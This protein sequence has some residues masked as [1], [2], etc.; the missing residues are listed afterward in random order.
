[1]LYKVY[2]DTE[3]VPMR[4]LQ[5]TTKSLKEA[6]DFGDKLSKK[7]NAIILTQKPETGLWTETIFAFRNEGKNWVEIG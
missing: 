7:D 4:H 2:K 6:F 3:G 5:F 1:M